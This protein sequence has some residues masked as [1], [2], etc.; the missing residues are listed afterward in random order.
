MNPP[1]PISVFEP[2]KHAAV[3]SVCFGKYE[4][5]ITFDGGNSL[6]IFAPFR[7]ARAPEIGG[8]IV[9]ECPL[10]ESSLMR[11]AGHHVSAIEIEADG[12]LT[13]RFSNGD[14]LVVYANDPLGEAYV[15]RVNGAEYVV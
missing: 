4:W 11:I 7:F 12:T 13:L 5:A 1:P 15:L 10:G 2:L 8:S 9:Q 14:V 3:W 6:R